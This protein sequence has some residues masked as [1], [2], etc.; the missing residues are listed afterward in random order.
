[1]PS[2]LSIGAVAADPAVTDTQAARS[3]VVS[4]APS[5]NS[6]PGTPN[7]TLQLNAALGLVVIEFLSKTGAITTSIP[8]QRELAAYRDGTAEPPGTPPPTVHQKA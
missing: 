6:T 3:A 7:P 4:P 5:A 8:T 2:D 1:M